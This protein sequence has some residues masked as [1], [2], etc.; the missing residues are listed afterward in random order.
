[1]NTNDYTK[2]NHFGI[3]FKSKRGWLMSMIFPKENLKNENI[4]SEINNCKASG[5]E[6]RV[7][8]VN[9]TNIQTF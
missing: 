6:T 4:Q 2:G 1:M 9:D 3:Q 7:V 5:W 8:E